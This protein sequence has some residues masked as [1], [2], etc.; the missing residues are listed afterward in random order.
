LNVTYR[1]IGYVTPFLVQAWLYASPVV[2]ST[3]IIPEGWARIAYG[4]NPMAGVVQGFRWAI[5]GGEAPPLALL[6]LSVAVALIFL[7]SGMIYFR[8]T[9]RTFADVV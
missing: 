7:V 6:G 1:D 8:R 5:L 3:S 4:L 2:Y 9:E